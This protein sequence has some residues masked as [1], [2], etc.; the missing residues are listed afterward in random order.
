M[1]A[2]SRTGTGEALTVS[3][4]VPSDSMEYWL[5]RL[6]ELAIPHKQPFEKFGKTRIGLKDADLMQL[7]LVFDEKVDGMPVWAG[8]TVHEEVAII[9]FEVTSLRIIQTEH[10]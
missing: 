4:S 2:Q 6:G 3:L 5:N 10:T 8:S 9:G 7:E 1:G